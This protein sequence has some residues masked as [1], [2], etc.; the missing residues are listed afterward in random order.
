[1]DGSLPAMRSLSDIVTP[2]VARPAIHHVEAI[3][4]RRVK[5]KRLTRAD[6]FALSVW[7]YGQIG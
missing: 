6:V 2:S 4:H 3:D 7:R 5:T 1:M